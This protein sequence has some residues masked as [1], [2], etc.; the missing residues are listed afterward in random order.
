[1]SDEL[2]NERSFA[3][4]LSERYR[5]VILDDDNLKEIRSMR[6]TLMNIYLFICSVLLIM[7]LLIGSLLFFTPIK[8]LIPGYGNVEGNIEFLN[9]KSQMGE[10]E[11]IIEAQ[12]VYIDGMKNMVSGGELPS[13][14]AADIDQVKLDSPQQTTSVQ[15]EQSGDDNQV[16]REVKAVKNNGLRGL[17]LAPPLKGEISSGFLDRKDHLGVDIVSVKNS[18]IKA[19][20][21]G[22]V[23]SS[24]WNLETGHSITIQHNNNLISVYKHN[25][26][27]LK[28]NGEKVKQGESIAI[29]GNTG[30]LSSGPH[31]HFE[32]W[33][34][35]N[36]MDP[37]KFIDFKD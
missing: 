7:A 3:E 33:F 5:L 20:K 19:I 1:M 22:I 37:I 36:P 12:S 29:I 23:V 34:D 16:A 14:I 24:D 10:M 28:S 26:K 11:E 27:L 13:S 15:S 17:Y 25:S 32:L 31:L 21:D 18:P 35:G 6:L 2:K 30:E 4:K 8:R 9:L